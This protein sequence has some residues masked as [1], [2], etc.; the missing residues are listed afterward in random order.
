[1]PTT[2]SPTPSTG[3]AGA[4]KR[5]RFPPG[6]EA[7]PGQ[8]DPLQ[9]P[10]LDRRPSGTRPGSR[11]PRCGRRSPCGRNIHR[12]SQAWGWSC[13]R[14]ATARAPRRT[15]GLLE[16]DEGAREDPEKGDRG[17]EAVKFRLFAAVL[18]GRGPCLLPLRGGGRRREAA[19]ERVVTCAEC[20]M[21][22][23][24]STRY[25]ARLVQGARTQI[26]ATSATSWAFIERTRP[27][28]YAAEVHDF[29]PGRGS[30]RTGVFRDRQKDVSSPRWAGASP[31]SGERPAR[32]GPPWTS[33]PC[34]GP[35]DESPPPSPPSSPGRS[36]W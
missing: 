4:R 8:P 15:R 6:K 29:T 16:F 25:T 7:P 3:S 27:R 9:Q 22:A 12:P 18:L 34:S 10:G 30:R 36:C 14:K 31:R 35:C 5:S 17:R 26:S 11:S 19:P 2:R 23:K 33:R 32:T 1:M 13:S 28:E 24:I 21:N 20:G